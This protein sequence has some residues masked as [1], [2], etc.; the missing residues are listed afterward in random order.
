MLASTSPGI[1]E[2]TDEVA[3][4]VDDDEALAVHVR[5]A[6][7]AVQPVD[8]DDL[9]VAEVQRVVDMAHRVHV[10]PADGHGHLVHQL[11]LLGDVEAHLCRLAPIGGVDAQLGRHALH[12][13]AQL[14]QLAGQ[15]RLLGLERGNLARRHAA[16]GGRRSRRVE[17]HLAAQQVG[18]AR[19]ARA[20]C[21]RQLEHAGRVLGSQLVEEAFDRGD[22]GKAVQPLAAAAVRPRSA[23][24]AASAPSAAPPTRPAG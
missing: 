3:E 19:L 17:G 5:R 9:H 22:V 24:R 7:H 21:A 4:G 6:T 23:G 8:A 2:L 18:P 11:L 14:R 13:R 16:F 15:P 20:R 12:Q 1:A 10:A